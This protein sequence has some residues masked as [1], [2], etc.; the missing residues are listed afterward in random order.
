MTGMGTTIFAEMSALAAATVRHHR[1]RTA[2]QRRRRGVSACCFRAIKKT[3]L[4]G[5]VVYDTR[6]M[7]G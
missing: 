5:K 1:R 7:W 4:A 6:G 2:R 3:Q